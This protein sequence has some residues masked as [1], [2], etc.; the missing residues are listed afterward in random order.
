MLFPFIYRRSGQTKKEQYRVVFRGGSGYIDTMGRTGIPA[1]S[2]L[3]LLLLLGLL[4]CSTTG[5]AP[6]EQPGYSEGGPVGRPGT[7][8][9]LSRETPEVDPYQPRSHQTGL[10]IR[11]LPDS[12]DVFLDNRYM[13]ITPLV[14]EKV[15]TGRH[16]LTL[17]KDGYYSESEWIYYSGRYDSYFFQLEEITGFLEVNAFPPDAQINYG[18]SWLPADRLHE[19]PAGSH[20]IRVR[21]FGYLETG[22]RAE[23]QPRALT[24]IT[25]RLQQA[26]FWLSDLR[27]DRRAFNPR[28]PGPLGRA[29]IR[30]RVSSYGSGRAT[31]TDGQDRVVM[32]QTLGRFTTWEQGFDWDGREPSGAPLPDGTYTV[33]IE[34]EAEDGGTSQSTR[35]SLTID[36]S[37]ML[38]YRSLWSGSAGLLYVPTADILPG[39]S[40]QFSSLVLV[41][42]ESGEDGTSIRA[43]VNLGLRVGLGPRNR[44]ELDTSVGG[45]I[46]YSRDTFDL[47]WF[48][49]AAFKASLRRAAGPFGLGAAAQAKIT[50]QNAYTDT[51]ANFSGLSLGL[52]AALQWGRF[53]LLFSPEVILSPWTV[54]YEED[55]DP[56]PGINAWLYGRFGM[57]V[58]FSSFSA[59]VSLSLRSQPFAEGFGLDMPLQGALEAHWLI[60]DT[61]LFL[62]LSL[63]GELHPSDFQLL[64]GAGLGV[65]D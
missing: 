8:G 36:S 1:L 64:G 25:V 18:G 19:L 34:A 40:A 55:F 54:G 42:G 43:P 38:L 9:V 56:D 3:L 30:F 45:I 63:A 49:S 5:E 53:A 61:H 11:S 37:I 20:S 60:P 41:H 4:A 23:I 39:G 62:S 26:A 33:L 51:L 17:R 52:P 22:L 7:G 10:E 35:L 15:E 58:D 59:G 27:T 47:P 13:G 48:A 31:I 12:A 57:L 65:L 14:I 6:L 50:Y 16:R 24:E 46:G 21:A 2:V 44:F 29:R 32:S 28:N